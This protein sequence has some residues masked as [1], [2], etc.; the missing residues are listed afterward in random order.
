MST[1]DPKSDDAKITER[2]RPKPYVWLMAISKG[3]NTG[4]A[5]DRADAQHLV[6]LAIKMTLICELA[7]LRVK[8]LEDKN[9]DN[10]PEKKAQDLATADR[11]LLT[12]VRELAPI[13]FQEK[14]PLCGVWSDSQKPDIVVVPGRDKEI[15]A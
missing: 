12:A 10:T 4:Y 11:G 5:P 15:K 6:D 3:M 2:P 7:E 13:K 14:K 8:I 9:P 1:S